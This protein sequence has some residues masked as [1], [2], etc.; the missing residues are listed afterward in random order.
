LDAKSHDNWND[1]EPV[2]NTMQNS[3][4]R[5]THGDV[6]SF[7]KLSGDTVTVYS[8]DMFGENTKS[9]RSLHIDDICFLPPTQASKIVALWNNS[10]SLATKQKLTA[11][12]HP[13]YFLKT[14]QCFLGHAGTIRQPSGYDGRVLYEGELG[15]VIGRTCAGVS[16]QKAEDYIFG[17][18]CVND[19]TAI[20]ILNEYAG[21]PQWTR[22]KN[23]E[24]FGVFGPGITTGVDASKLLIETEL[25]GRVRQS[26]SVSD[27]FFPPAV[28]VSR[29]SSE[30]TLVAGDIIACGTGPGALPMRHGSQVDIVIQGVGRLTNKFHNDTG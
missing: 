11:P 14:P 30:V 18:T 22:A 2:M 16:E 1:V 6:E 23:F 15:V 13:L 8:G 12:D 25:N 17:Y 5:F 26:F 7:G 29:I 9:D 24:T 3:W 27:M 10:R 19:V 21:F 28:L 4:I 20:G